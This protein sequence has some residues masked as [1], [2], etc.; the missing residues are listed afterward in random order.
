MVCAIRIA[1]GPITTTNIAGKIVKI[2]GNRI[3]TGSLWPWAARSSSTDTSVAQLPFLLRLPPGSPDTEGLAV[4][5]AANR[6]LKEE[7]E[8]AWEADGLLTLNALLRRAVAP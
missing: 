5:Q 1:P 7:I 6:R 4:L 3:L 2:T 8:R